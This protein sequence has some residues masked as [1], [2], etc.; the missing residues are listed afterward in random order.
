[1]DSQR[2][3]AVLSPKMFVRPSWE[4]RLQT[5][6]SIQVD[7]FDV[8]S[9]L[10]PVSRINPDWKQR[11]LREFYPHNKELTSCHSVSSV[12]IMCPNVGN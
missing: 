11:Y 7:L 9:S 5:F 1:M 3:D 12:L 6:F 10:H 2:L 4:S 8:G